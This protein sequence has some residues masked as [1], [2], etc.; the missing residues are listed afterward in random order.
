MY[1]KVEIYEKRERELLIL[2]IYKYIFYVSINSS[3][4]SSSSTAAS[5]NIYTQNTGNYNKINK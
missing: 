3:T 2:K 1:A 5:S 4:S